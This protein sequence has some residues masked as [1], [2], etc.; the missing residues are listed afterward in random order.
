MNY[1]NPEL[2]DQLAAEYVL[3]T[4]PRLVR[5][6]F[7]RLLAGEPAL[8]RAVEEWSGRLGPIDEAADTEEPPPHVWRRIEQRL[9]L[10]GTG[11]AAVPRTGTAGL[12]SRGGSWFGSLAFWRGATLAAAA[13]ALALLYIAVR[14]APPSTVVAVLSDDKGEP[15]WVALATAGRGNLSVAAV[16]PVALD[17][18]HALELWVIA[19]GKPQPLGLLTPQ[20]GR[21][22]L[23]E[24]ALVPR[25]GVLAVSLE[26]A[27]GSPTGLPT[28]PVQY[29]GPVLPHAP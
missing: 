16:R 3:G 27:G 20:P 26:P 13:A 5:R 18:A 21:P 1:D 4:M 7:E 12:T 25:D 29:K 15:G 22:L 10:P 6:R 24:A 19:G 23:V 28:G 11:S 8:R 14:P 17:Q 9:A 2:R